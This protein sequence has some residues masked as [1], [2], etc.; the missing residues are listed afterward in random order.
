MG[1][2][3]LLAIVQS[4]IRIPG[5]DG[6]RGRN[7]RVHRLRLIS[8]AGA[9]QAAPEQGD[10]PNRHRGQFERAV[11]RDPGADFGPAGSVQPRNRD[12][13]VEFA[14]FR[15]QS[16]AF[17]GRLDPVSQMAERAIRLDPDPERV[18]SAAGFEMAETVE[19]QLDR[20]RPYHRKRRLQ[21]IRDDAIDFADKAQGQVKVF[22]IDPAGP[23]EAFLDL[24]D[25]ILD[26]IG[27]CE[28]YEQTAHDEP[29][30]TDKGESEAQQIA[31]V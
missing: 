11:V 20:R 6:K 25:A 28:G 12:V 14:A 27:K 7:Q 16:G 19:I 17:G 18:G 5:R 24:G 4:I 8:C 31:S 1:P 15:P 22:R 30:F 3:R 26:R 2:I 13:R 10:F 21:I 9:P 29:P 23:I